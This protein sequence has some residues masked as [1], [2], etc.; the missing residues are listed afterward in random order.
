MLTVSPP[1]FA[2]HVVVVRGIGVPCCA[3]DVLR[4][5]LRFLQAGALRCATFIAAAGRKQRSRRVIAVM[6]CVD[7]DVDLPPAHLR[8]TT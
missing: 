5:S 1:T 2:D 7:E 3:T 4:G 6:V 8:E